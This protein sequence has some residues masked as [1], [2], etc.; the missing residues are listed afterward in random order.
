[1]PVAVEL[2]DSGIPLPISYIDLTRLSKRHVVGT[3]KMRVV[4]SVIILLPQNHADASFWAKLQ[5]E[6]STIV[7]HP[8]IVETVDPQP[9]WSR[10]QPL[11]HGSNEIP[12]FI[13]LDQWM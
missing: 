4:V 5:H 13:K 12:V 1:M 7:R 2:H 11:S 3:I 8:D 9:M 6:V 10:E